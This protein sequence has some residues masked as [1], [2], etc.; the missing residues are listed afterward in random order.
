MKKL[1]R[2]NIFILLSLVFTIVQPTMAQKK[3]ISIPQKED[4]IYMLNGEKKQGQIKSM[5]GSGLKFI[6]AG[7]TVVYTL[8]RS[9]IYKI[10]FASG[11]TEEVNPKITEKPGVQEPQKISPNLV[12]IIPFKVSTINE[13]TAGDKGE[14]IQ[15]EAYLCLS[16][17]NNGIYKYQE[18]RITN[19]ILFK[20]GVNESNIKGYSS[21][22][23]CQLLGVEY[24]IQGSLTRSSEETLNTQ[25]RKTSEH[26]EDGKEQRKSVNT[27]V[28]KNYDSEILLGIYN[29]KNEKVYLKSRKSMLDDENSYKNTLVYL[30]K[31]CPVYNKN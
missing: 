29:V 2:I 22:E 3:N 17:N 14:K 19:L 7:E 9:E 5:E 11:R 15:E 26:T 20:K 8:K 4:V 24:I 30:L 18:P 28:N 31:R 21:E 23:L 13:Q 12:A 1:V 10:E 16:K 6:H 27:K 25:E